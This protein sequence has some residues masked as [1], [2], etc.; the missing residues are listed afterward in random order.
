MNKLD[1][2]SPIPL[3]HQ[4]K[5]VLRGMVESGLLQPGE[6]IPAE[7]D[8]AEEYQIS[9]STVR[10]AILD[11]VRKGIFVRQR[12]R[13]TFVA[14]PKEEISYIVDFFPSKMG[15]RHENISMQHS[16]P[17]VSVSKLLQ[18]PENGVVYSV[19]R[20]RY[21]KDLPSVLEKSYIAENSC[22]EFNS[23]PVNY[24]G[25]LYEWINSNCQ[26][27][28]TKAVTNIEPV[29]LDQYE[30]DLF[31]LSGVIP[32]FLISR[33]N[34][35]ERGMPVVYSKSIVRGDKFRIEVK[36]SEKGVIT[37]ENR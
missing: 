1:I 25:K 6:K 7:M 18:I 12:G 14:A 35:D 2:Q 5:E 22:P 32:G 19:I 26:K 21:I 31:H 24:E 33:L 3:Y 9:R 34:L 16:V 8:I 30:C 17:P 10:N 13:G 20:L 23:L 27:K 4:L 29:I 37:V 36:T 28:I 15:A 11:L